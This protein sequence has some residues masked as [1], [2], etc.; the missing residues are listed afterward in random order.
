MAIIIPRGEKSDLLTLL[1][2]PYLTPRGILSLLLL[3]LLLL[4][5]CLFIV[6]KQDLGFVQSGLDSVWS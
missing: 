4:F 2:L 1:P 5:V 3:L 6:L